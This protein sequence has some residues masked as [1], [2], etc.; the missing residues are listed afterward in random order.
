MTMHHILKIPLLFY[1]AFL[2]PAKKICFSSS[3]KS[4]ILFE[5]H[6]L[7]LLVVDTVKYAIIGFDA[8]E[9]IDPINPINIK[10]YS[11]GSFKWKYKRKTLT[12]FK[13]IKKLFLLIFLLQY[14]IAF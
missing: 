1:H 11:K 12:S 4:S 14:L 13:S 5:A 3:V 2:K 6:A 9:E 8:T 7:A 10:K